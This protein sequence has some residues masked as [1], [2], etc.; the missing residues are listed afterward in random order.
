MSGNLSISDPLQDC[1][2]WVRSKMPEPVKEFAGYTAS[3]GFCLLFAS[4]V[5]WICTSFDSRS[6]PT[7]SNGMLFSLS[8]AAVF[9]AVQSQR[10]IR[11]GSLDTWVHHELSYL[12]GT[13][14]VNHLS[15]YKLSFSYL[16]SMPVLSLALHTVGEKYRT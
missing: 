16:Q 6:F 5:R 15:P 11:G 14:L 10:L 4:T 13:A 12:A 1:S 3:A 7:L 8:S 9:Q 2:S